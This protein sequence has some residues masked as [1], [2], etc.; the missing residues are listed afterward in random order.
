VKRAVCCLWLFGAACVEQPFRPRSGVPTLDDA[1]PGGGSDGFIAVSSGGAH[2]CGLVADGYAYCWGSNEFGQLGADDNGTTCARGD[3]AIPCRSTPVPVNGALQFQ[4]I[5]AG[6]VHTCG[7]ATTSRV[8]CWGDNPRGALGD[9]NVSRS[10][11]PIAVASTASFSDVVTGGQHSCGL[12]TDGV[13]LCWGANDMGQ[14]GSGGSNGSGVPVAANTALRFVSIAAGDLRTCARIADGTAYCWGSTWVNYIGG[15]DITRAQPSPSRIQSTLSF[16]SIAAG[17]NTTCGISQDNRAYCWEANSAGAMGD[18]SV[19]GSLVPVEVRSGANLVAVS[20]GDLQSCGIAD[21]GFAY[22]WGANGSG[23]LGVSPSLVP[24][25]CTE[26]RVPCATRP[27]RVSG[28]RVFQQISA[29][30][31]R[32]ACGLTLAGH[33]YCWGAGGMGQRGDGRTSAAEWSPVKTLSP[34]IVS[35]SVIGDTAPQRL[36]P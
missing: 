28:W 31:G 8:Y 25:R 24:L 2:T 18:G 3:R 33:I 22:C 32:H 27:M 11:T 23:E 10:T 15:R 20:S 30:Q 6:G 16:K 29:G 35:L 26:E 4:K 36:N 1:G 14:L 9:P 5:A 34:P 12:R 21:T 7:L 17:T 13:V 19:T